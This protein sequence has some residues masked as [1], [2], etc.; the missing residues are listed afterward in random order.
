MWEGLKLSIEVHSITQR[1][2]WVQ[3]KKSHDQC[4]TQKE[5]LV[6]KT[7]ESSNI[8]SHSHGVKMATKFVIYASPYSTN[9]NQY[10]YFL[11]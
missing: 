9:K 4:T 2:G 8:S 5:D 7:L 11:Y 3:T 6:C 10:K 1:P